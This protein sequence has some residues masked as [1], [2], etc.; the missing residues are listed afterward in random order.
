MKIS[1]YSYDDDDITIP[2]QYYYYY[3]YECTSK[4]K[5]NWLGL[6]DSNGERGRI[7]ED[8]SSHASVGVKQVYIYI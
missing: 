2:L 8:L 3:Y 1:W 6:G 4:C 7:V 5:E